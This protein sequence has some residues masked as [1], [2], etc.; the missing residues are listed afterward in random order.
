MPD[1]DPGRRQV[2]TLPET[3]SVVDLAAAMKRD[4]VGCIVIV[5]ADER[6]LGVVTDRDLALRVVAAERDT[7]STN[8]AAIM[9][10]PAV[11]ALEGE[12]LERSLE[13][14]THHGIRRLPVVDGERVVGIIA[15]DDLL[16]RFGGEL[17]DLAGAAQR[18][19]AD[20][21]LAT[22]WPRLRDEVEARLHDLSERVRKAGGRGAEALTRE[23]DALRERIRRTLQ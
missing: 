12:P 11:S 8:A 17:G 9:S 3:A 4:A 1:T 2:S 14:M 20:A 21:R 7:G 18:Q 22:R 5:D 13:K 19:I 15:L 16:A 10:Q 23:L 6:P